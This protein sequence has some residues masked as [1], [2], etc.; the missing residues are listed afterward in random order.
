MFCTL[1][2]MLTLIFQNPIATGFGLLG[3]ACLA[4]WP[5]F[6]S[7][8]LMLTMYLGNTLAFVVY[9]ALLHHWTAVAM[10][11]LMAI[12]TLTAIWIFQ[13]PGMRWIYYAV[14]PA[15]LVISMATWEGF[16][17]L[18]AVTAATFSTLGRMQSN[19][20]AL[21]LLM[22]A[23]TPCWAAHDLVVASLPGLMADM[24]SMLIGGTMLLRRCPAIGAAILAI[25]AHRRDGIKSR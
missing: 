11:G 13:W 22:L 15:L 2:H 7:R 16:A 24:L 4:A 9:Y 23:S 20:T 10:N 8:S 25:M 12:Q 3:I 21:R 1:E 18:F 14:M 6:R 19:E 17:S 5:L